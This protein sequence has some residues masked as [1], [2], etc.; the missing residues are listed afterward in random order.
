MIAAVGFMTN[1]FGLLT[2]QA[3]EISSNPLHH[4]TTRAPLGVALTLALV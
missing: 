4:Y 1:I 2:S 3:D